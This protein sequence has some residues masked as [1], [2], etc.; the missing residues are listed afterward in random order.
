[1]VVVLKFS[2]QIGGTRF[3]VCDPEVW[4]SSI[5]GFENQNNLCRDLLVGNVSL[6]E[7]FF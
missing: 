2:E 4:L 3:G 7:I 1:M 6:E 5:V